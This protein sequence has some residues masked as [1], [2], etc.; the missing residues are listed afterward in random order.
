MTEVTLEQKQEWMIQCLKAGAEIYGII[1]WKIL[2][3][4]YGKRY[5]VS[6]AEV[7]EIFQSIDSEVRGFEEYE[8]DVVDAGLVGKDSYTL[9]KGYQEGKPYFIP[10]EKEIEV[11]AENGFLNNTSEAKRMFEAVNKYLEPDK[12]EAKKVLDVLQRKISMNCSPSRLLDELGKVLGREFHFENAED[13]GD[14]METLM[15]FNNNCRMIIHK[16]NT[17]KWLSQNPGIGIF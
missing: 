3:K 11:I 2:R 4:I 8:G 1:P 10:N 9:L 16:G 6:E 17:P 14:F 12:D 5:K 15:Y 13:E 7:R